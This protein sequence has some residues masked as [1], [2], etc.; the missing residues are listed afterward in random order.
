MHFQEG[1]HLVPLLDMAHHR[2][3]CP[4]RVVVNDC[5]TLVNTTQSGPVSNPYTHLS[6]PGILNT[7]R[8]CITW[9]AAS[10]L[11]PGEDVCFA[12]GYLLP[13]RA[14]LQYGFIPPELLQAVEG[15][16]AAAEKRQEV[17]ASGVRGVRSIPVFGM[18]RHDYQAVAEGGLPWRFRVD[19]DTCPEP[20]QGVCG[21]VRVRGGGVRRGKGRCMP[22]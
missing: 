9:T 16:A 13:D 1:G 22:M 14:M 11:K 3:G 12:H 15:A 8:L 2:N 4:H 21:G 18:D 17:S 20:F 5:A 19:N 6:S 7:T 10:D